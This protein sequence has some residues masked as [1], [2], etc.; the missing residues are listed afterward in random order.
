MGNPVGAAQA[1]LDAGRQDDIVLVGMDH[2]LRALEYLRDGVIS[3]LGV[4]DCYKMGFDTIQVAI[5]IADGV[6]PGDDTYPE[7]TEEQTTIIYP[8]DAQGVIDF[9]YDGK[10]SSEQ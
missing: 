5:M 3:A 4:Q 9:L 8:E 2:D 1:V 7:Q 10:T 6:Q